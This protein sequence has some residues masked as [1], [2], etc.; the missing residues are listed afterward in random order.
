MAKKILV[1]GAAGLIGREICNQLSKDFIVVG[2][3]NNF[4][5]PGFTPNCIFIQAD[6]IEYLTNTDND[7]DYI[8]HM[9]AI[10]GTKY[11]YEIPTTLIENNFTSDLNIFKFAAKNKKCKLIYAS[12]SEVIAGTDQFP[13]PELVDVHIKNIH[14]PRWSY[15]FTK[16]LSENYLMN[17]RLDFLIIRFF[18]IFGKDSGSGHFVKDIIEKIAKEDYSIIGANETRSFCRVEDAVDA[19]LQIYEKASKDVVNIGSDEEITIL[20]AANLI[21]EQLNKDINWRLLPSRS[22]SVSRRNPSLEK[23]KKYYPEFLPMKFK[24]AIKDLNS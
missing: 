5:Y 13:S 3:D 20:E 9:L 6:L 23:L 15:R 2:V 24:D 19:L 4:R 16:M 17:S 18:N 10:N 12:S 21:V 8:F 14:D 11:F 22:N 7:F 1:T